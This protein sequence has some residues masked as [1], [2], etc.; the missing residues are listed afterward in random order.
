M[1]SAWFRSTFLRALMFLQITDGLPNFWEELILK[2]VWIIWST[3][4]VFQSQKFYGTKFFII[5]YMS[6]HSAWSRGTFLRALIFLQIKDG[7]PNFWGEPILKS[8][9]IIWSP[10]LYFN[11]KSFLDLKAL[12]SIAFQ[13]ILHDSGVPISEPWYFYKLRMGDVVSGGN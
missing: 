4:S 5:H 13:C 8:V 11:F 12:S 1:H 10:L 7:I 9:W 2:N 6:V 3:P